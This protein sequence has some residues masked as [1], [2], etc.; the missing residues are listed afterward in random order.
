LY[1]LW[2]PRPKSLPNSWR[3]SLASFRCFSKRAIRRST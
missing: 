2:P 3:A 1:A